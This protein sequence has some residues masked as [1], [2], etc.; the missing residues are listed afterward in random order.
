VKDGLRK[1]QN[2]GRGR[3]ETFI[4]KSTNAERR[5]AEEI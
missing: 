2:N 5:T 4:D 3:A 1:V